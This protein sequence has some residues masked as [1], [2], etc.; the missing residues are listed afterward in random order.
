MHLR[1]PNQHTHWF[2]SFL[3]NTFE[4]S[5]DEVRES[6]VRVLLER[7]LASKPHPWGLLYTF[8]QL[9]AD[10]R[11]LEHEFITSKFPFLREARN[12]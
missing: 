10:G 8:S 3:L 12:R 11:L 6:I 7:V 2:S 9:L 5:G 1:F 4:S